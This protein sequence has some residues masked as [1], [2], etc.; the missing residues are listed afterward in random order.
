M[1]KNPAIPS[2]IVA[3]TPE[4]VRKRFDCMVLRWQDIRKEAATDMRF[5]TGDPWPQ[6]E[7]DN[8]TAMN[9]LCLSFDELSQYINQLVNGVRQNKR[10]PKVTPAGNGANDQTAEMRAGM[11]KAIGYKSNADAAR[12]TAF[13]NAAMRSY[14]VYKVKRRYISD[15]SELQE[16]RLERM[17]NPDVWYDDPDATE[18]DYSDRR[19]G[20]ELDRMSKEEFRRRFP[21]AEIQSFSTELMQLA[22]AWIRDDEIQVASYWKAHERKRTRLRFEDDETAYLDEAGSGAGVTDDGYLEANGMKPRKVRNYREMIDRFI[23]EYKFNGVELLEENPW[24]ITVT[25]PQTGKKITGGKYIPYIFITGKELFVDTGTGSQRVL[26]SL[27]RMARTPYMAYCYTR[28]A[29]L[30]A[31]Q[32]TSK[33]PYFIYEGQFENHEKEA[34]SLHKLPV[35]YQEFKGITEATGDHL[36]PPPTRPSY[37]PEVQQLEVYAQAARQ[38]IQAAIGFSNPQVQRNRTS[39][40]SGKALQEFEDQG[41]IKTFHFIDNYDRALEFEGRILNDL[42]PVVYDTERQVSIIGNDEKSKVITLNA[43][44]GTNQEY[45]KQQGEQPAVEYPTDEGDHELTISVGPSRDSQR[46]DENDLADSLVQNPAVIQAA[47]AQPQSTAAKL[48]AMAIKLKNIG[49]LGDAM[50][51]IID[52]EAQQQQEIPPQVQQ[53]IQ[54]QAQQLQ[55]ATALVG[56]LQ[57]ELKEKTEIRKMELENERVIHADD[58]RTKIQVALITKGTAAIDAQLQAELQAVEKRWDMLHESELAPG[59]D[60]GQRGIHP[61]AIPE[62]AATGAGAEAL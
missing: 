60:E 14:G 6:G 42:I 12:I 31:I 18:A 62:P 7:R 37:I 38:A 27:I 53:A 43:Q 44:P 33:S 26:Q 5:M 22:P 25:N 52:P 30:E 23:V 39:P 54:Q 32:L 34:A 3:P 59:P 24:T 40:I 58:N 16:L 11:I 15:S 45:S 35:A 8:R 47:I 29:Q 50:A 17:P 2:Y 1:K 9:R 56:H 28:T 4:E 61:S 49:P 13:E 21:N 20:F 10:A 57:Q 41:D 51:D 46:Q 19:D 48:T 55:Q 36:L